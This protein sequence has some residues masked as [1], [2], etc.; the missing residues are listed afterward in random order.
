MLKSEKL[1]FRFL[2][3]LVIVAAFFLLY[4]S[5]FSYFNNPHVVNGSVGLGN[6]YHSTTTRTAIVGVPYGQLTAL[7]GTNAVGGTLGSIVITGANSGQINIYDGTS[8][9]TNSQT[10][11]S[12]LVVIPASTVAGTYTFD[13]QFYRGLV[14]EV[15]GLAPT[16]T[17]TYRNN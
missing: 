2:M 7:T 16:T 5:L 8:T 11:T 12:T 9:Q 13:V 1:F 15:I 3:P 17:I 10:G 4:F 14:I 6:D